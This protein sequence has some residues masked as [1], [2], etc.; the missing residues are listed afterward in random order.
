MGKFAKDD[1]YVTVDICGNTPTPNVAAISSSLSTWTSTPTSASVEVW[2]EGFT[3]TQNSAPLLPASY[4]LVPVD[5]KLVVHWG[6]HAA[7]YLAMIYILLDH[8]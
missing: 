7:I 5:G 6:K 1:R 2:F 4:L 3:C 8:T